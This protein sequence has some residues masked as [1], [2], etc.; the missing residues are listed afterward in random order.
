MANT[1]SSVIADLN[2]HIQPRLGAAREERRLTNR[3]RA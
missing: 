1:T 2:R 3:I